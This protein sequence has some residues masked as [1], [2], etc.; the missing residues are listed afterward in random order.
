MKTLIFALSMLIIISF[1]ISNCQYLLEDE[2][3]SVE[4]KPTAT[5]TITKWEQDYDDYFHEW[6]Y[7]YVY[8]EVKNTGSIRI[9]Y[10]QVWFTVT[11][12]DGS[13]YTEWTNGSDVLPGTTASDYTIIDIAGKEAT[14]V[15]IY[16]YELTHYDW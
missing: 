8:F 10:Y 7:V 4:N 5:F 6:E 1:F 2:S 15:I 16:N 11:C 9:D 3:P 13:Q 14:S 12:T